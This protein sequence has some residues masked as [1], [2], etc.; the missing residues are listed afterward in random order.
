MYRVSLRSLADLENDPLMTLTD[1]GRTK[2][3]ETKEN[4]PLA[5]IPLAIATLLATLGSA[6]H[7][8]A[9]LRTPGDLVRA[10]GCPCTCTVPPSQTS[11]SIPPNLSSPG[12]AAHSLT[13][14]ELVRTGCCPCTCV[15]PPSHMSALTPPNLPSPG[16]A[17]V[18]GP[19]P[20]LPLTRSQTEEVNESRPL[21][22]IPLAIAT[23]L[24]VLGSVG[25][26]L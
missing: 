5:S 8:P 24:A 15:V 23:L 4:R 22:S 3:K 1:W 25:T 12:L 21:A 17:A 18:H 19:A 10:G 11:A 16:L 7:S 9:L 26:T 13:P 20:A 6:A 14:G 2:T